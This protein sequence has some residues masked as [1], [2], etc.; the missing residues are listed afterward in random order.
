MPTIS[1]FYG[2]I[3]R[4]Y[5]FDTH[6]HAIPHIHASHGDDAAVFSL[7]DGSVLA[8]SLPIR[9]TRLVQAWIELRTE[10]LQADWALATQGEPL[11]K[12]EPLR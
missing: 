4:M 10:Q 9:Q 7:D 11:F 3:I 6:Q 12:I 8:G 2:I 1:T 5:F